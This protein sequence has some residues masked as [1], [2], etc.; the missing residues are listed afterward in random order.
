MS[1]KLILYCK[2]F[3]RDFQRAKRLLK[4]VQKHNRDNIPFFISAPSSEY[5]LLRDTLG[6]DGYEYITDESIWQFKYQMDGWRS[7]QIVKSNVW[8]AVHTDN[9]ICIDSDQFFIKDFYMNDFIHSSGTIYS[10]V[11][12]NKEV[13]QYV[14]NVVKDVVS[15]YAIDAIHFDDY[16]PDANNLFA[17]NSCYS[18]LQ[19]FPLFLVRLSLFYSSNLC[20]Y[21]ARCSCGFISW[22][23]F[24][25]RLHQETD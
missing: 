22:K 12:E 18:L 20:R 24:D 6:T 13:Q 11:H 7:Q 8:K 2:T 19:G 17:H 9:Y 1:Y 10:L 21:H 5:K 15:R 16:F 3:G 25:C 4:S 23:V 14:T